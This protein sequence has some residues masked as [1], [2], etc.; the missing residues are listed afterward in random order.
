MAINLSQQRFLQPLRSNI[1]GSYD[2]AVQALKDV[3]AEIAKENAI[4]SKADGSTIVARYTDG[5]V[6][7]SIFGIY[8][9]STKKIT[10]YSHDD[11]KLQGLL[12]GIDGRL[13]VIQGESNVEGS[14]KKAVA[15]LLG[16]AAE[17]YNTLGKLEDKIQALDGAVGEGG[18]V[19]TQ[20]QNA[21]NGLDATVSTV[22]EGETHLVDVEVVEV[23]GKLTSATLNESKLN[24][25]LQAIEK[26]VTDEETRA[27]GA[28]DK[29]EASI[30]L[31]EDGSHIATE[32]NYTKEA[33]TIVGEIAA[34]DAQ[35]KVNADAIAAE[36]TK[37]REEEGKL[38]EA[39]ANV[40]AAAKS[41]SI[42]EV[43][44]NLGANIEKAYQLQ[45][46]V[47]ENSVLVGSLIEIQKD[48][49]LVSV[50][51]VDATGKEDEKGQYLQFVYNL[52]DG[53]QKEVTIDVTHFLA[54]SE[55]KNGLQVSESG[56]V[57]VKLAEGSESFLSV[58]ED[59]VKL[60]GVQDAINAAVKGEKERAELAEKGLSDRLVAL[61]SGDN[62]VA[63]QIEKAVTSLDSTAT[64][65]NGNFVNITVVEEDGKL[66]S[67]SVD[68]SGLNTEIA[69][70]E[71][72]VTDEAA[73]AR[74]E[75]GKLADAIAAEKSRA[76]G[77]EAELA[78]AIATEKSRAEGVE[79]QLGKD[80]AAEKSRAE[81]KEAELAAAIA[82]QSAAAK[83]EV[84]QGGTNSMLS[85]TPSIQ[86][87][88]GQD[89]H[90]RYTVDLLDTW[91]CGTFTA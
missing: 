90:T 78:A 29:I 35:V 12:N 75:E 62:S 47:G 56:E 31:G 9:H 23:D 64:S 5:S 16:D 54:E 33:T 55:F 44:E 53:T 89:G 39:I 20:I 73:K 42:V 21:I 87:G 14:I 38:A 18:S 2:L 26:S 66:T 60:S 8:E 50:A 76:E 65:T 15:D 41:Y 91:D 13:D 27:K 83:T 82:A 7:K 85:V 40:S 10:I 86:N 17:G 81:G 36:A 25:E 58:G 77:K 80:I 1:L 19:S 6:V 30:G 51:L 28:E 57:S 67:A 34:L 3:A 32:G 70:I 68:E 72:S 11:E 43:K 37:A 49:S 71:K 46:T 24:E 22:I 45:E 84:V 4:S 74:E 52:S 59:G 48:D 63:K 69:A 61:E 88:E 79:E